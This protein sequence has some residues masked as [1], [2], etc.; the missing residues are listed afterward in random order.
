MPL[1][2]PLR[3]GGPRILNGGLGPKGGPGGGLGPL[4]KG[5]GGLIGGRNPRVARKCGGGRPPLMPGGGAPGIGKRPPLY[6]LGNMRAP[7]PRKYPKII[8]DICLSKLLI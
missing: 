7:L 5:P 3:P 1:G 4:I 8:N 2:G 6:P